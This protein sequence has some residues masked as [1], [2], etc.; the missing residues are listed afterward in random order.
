MPLIALTG[1]IASGKSTVA[2]RLA[3]LGAV[4]VDADALSR[5]VVE[6]GEPALDAIRAAF[7]ERVL[8]DDG[9]LDR[10][11]L[12]AI[13]FAD[14]AARH[15]LNDIV[16]PAVVRRSHDLFRA[17]VERDPDGVV[18]YDVPLIDA[19]GVGEFERIVVTDAPVE[20]RVTRLV[21]LRG[22][23]EEDARARIASQL[24]DD[25]RRALATDVIDTSGTLET[26]LAQTDDLWQRLRG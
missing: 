8:Q 21:E 26:T 10:P 4:V 11:A 17:A 13:V 23:S 15:R 20:T 7:G 25:A 18:V 22:M 14:P 16:H 1:G 24:D 3:E 2:R 12:G 5:E 9:R 6:P 19:R